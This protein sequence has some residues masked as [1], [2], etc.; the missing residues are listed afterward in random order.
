M[1]R[2]IFSLAIVALLFSGCSKDQP[3]QAVI[4]NLS[5]TTLVSQLGSITLKANVT[6]ALENV[7][8][9]SVNDV[10]VEGATGETFEFS[11]DKTG[12]YIITLTVENKDG[13]ASDQIA[14]TVY[15][16]I[17]FEDGRLS[18]YWAGPTAYGENLYSSFGAGQY[19]G[20]DDAESGLYM[21][22]NEA[23]DWFTGELS[24][25]FWNGGI[26][27]SQWNSMTAEGIDNQCSVYYSDVST[28]NGGFD[29]SKTF[30]VN[31]GEG[32]VSF[33]DGAT[34]C[35]FHYFWVTN[36]TFSALSMKNGDAFAEKF[37]Y[38]NRDWFKLTITAEDK[39]GNAAETSIEF[40]LADFR[41]ASS[42]GII[43][44]WTKVDLTPLGSN[45]HTLKFSL[46]SSDNSQ[47]G[48][49]TPAYFCFDNLA[50][51]K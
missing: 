39:S 49:N 47:W 28:G 17:D 13:K 14:V 2:L 20:Y 37:T 6:G 5:E 15:Y 30:A 27:I 26:A 32:T 16:L 34:E 25:E 29:G 11:S 8:A 46:Q 3:P 31:N 18:S 10:T 33:A 41:T 35:K 23:P 45:V 9:W 4:E 7:I 24:R 22:L 42:P 51:F 19:I 21:M 48:M 36:S 12:E 43:T 1:K 38:E 44:Q 40:Y 50:L